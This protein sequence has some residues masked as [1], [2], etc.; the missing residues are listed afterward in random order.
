MIDFPGAWDQGTPAIIT[1]NEH[2]TIIGIF[3]RIE[4]GA[5]ILAQISPSTINW[6]RQNADWTQESTCNVRTWTEENL[7]TS[8]SCGMPSENRVMRS[9][10]IYNGNDA[11]TNKYPW[12]VLV[13]NTQTKNHE[14]IIHQDP[15][16]TNYDI[17]SGTLISNKGS[18][19]NT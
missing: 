3:L 15:D 5:A 2:S 9:N 12:Q 8:C 1:E 18:L 4:N 6:I 16:G 17:C 11:E 14:G 13:F 7:F 10:R 19:K